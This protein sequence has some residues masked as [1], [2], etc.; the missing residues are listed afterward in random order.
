MNTTLPGAATAAPAATRRRVILAAFVIALGGLLFGYDTG[1]I[2]GAL[3]AMTEYFHL[4][5]LSSG[6]VVSSLVVGAAIGAF[7]SG[8]L[9]DRFGRR[10]VLLSASIIF[11]V[12]SLLAAFATSVALMVISRV[13]LG[14]AVGVASS[15]VPVFITELAPAQVRGRLVSINQLMIV[16]G[17]MLA[18]LA[19]FA[20]HG[21]PHDWRWMVGIAIVP[22]VVF[23]LGILS[24]AESPRWLAVNGQVERA[25]AVLSTYRSADDVEPELADILAT[26]EA[27]VDG[28]GWSRL[29]DP[30]M[31][32]VLIAG[33]GLQILGQLTGVNAVVYYA[34]SI[35]ESAGL[36]A[37]SALLATVGVGV[38]NLIATFVGMA[39]VDKI[40]RT[41]LLAIGSAIQAMCLAG[42]AILL[43]VGVTSG[44]A[45]AIGVSFIFA[46]IA[47][48]ATGLN[49]VV[50]IIPSELYP[51]RIR[52]TAMSLTLAVNWTMSFLV[53]LTFLSLFDA[54]GGVGTFGL[55]AVATACLCLFALKVIPETRG[56][57]LEDIERDY[58][59]GTR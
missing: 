21:V 26:Q 25:R 6:V 17:I 35:F 39:L 33:I 46:Y 18:Y 44:V 37:S 3:P 53:S 2:S 27:D 38:V 4:T 47:A 57:T 7:T 55:Y 49:V 19:N 45:S 12:G 40:G 43:V 50:F 15:L 20:L 8:R 16:T 30:S 34:P 58:V 11:V 9:S 29:A 1:V 14:L 41:R 56:K 54:F 22:S 32:R 31:R 28:K 59:T 51:L 23:G 10:P 13:I 5:S 48:V 36:G 24:L 52:A 42:F